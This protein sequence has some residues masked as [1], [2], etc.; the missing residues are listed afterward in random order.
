MAIPYNIPSLDIIKSFTKP[1]EFENWLPGLF[2]KNYYNGVFPINSKEDTITEETLFS[3]KTAPSNDDFNISLKRYFLFLYCLKAK[4]YL[5]D[6]ASKIINYNIDEY[7]FR[8]ELAEYLEQVQTNQIRNKI[9]SSLT[10]ELVKKYSLDKGLNLETKQLS[11]YFK[12]AESE[13]F[14]NSLSRKL[15]VVLYESVVKH[16]L[17][18]SLKESYSFPYKEDS[19]SGWINKAI[20]LELGELSYFIDMEG[21]PDNKSFPV[22]CVLTKKINIEEKENVL[23]Q[24]NKFLSNV[25]GRD[26]TDNCLANIIGEP[27]QFENNFKKVPILK[28]K[29][30]NSS[31]YNAICVVYDFT[32]ILLS[33]AKNREFKAQTVAEAGLGFLTKYTLELNSID[34]LIERKNVISDMFDKYFPSDSFSKTK[35]QIANRKRHATEIY[36]R[37][38]LLSQDEIKKSLEPEIKINTLQLKTAYSDYVDSIISTYKRKRSTNIQTSQYSKK[39]EKVTLHFDSSLNLLAITCVP[40]QI[41]DRATISYYSPFIINTGVSVIPSIT[42][43]LTVN[44]E[45]NLSDKFFGSYSQNPNGKFKEYSNNLKKFIGYRICFMTKTL[46][47]ML[48]DNFEGGK[49]HIAQYDNLSSGPNYHASFD[50]SS[51]LYESL[52]EI[53]YIEDYFNKDG[54]F[55]DKTIEI[56]SLSTNYTE[57]KYQSLS[58]QTLAFYL[59]NCYEGEKI[60]D[61]SPDVKVFGEQ[62]HYPVLACLPSKEE[63]DTSNILVSLNLSDNQIYQ[64]VLIIDNLAKKTLANLKDT[65]QFDTTKVVNTIM[66]SNAAC[67]ADVILVLEDLL[68]EILDF[69]PVTNSFAGFAEH[70]IGQEL[71]NKLLKITDRIPILDIIRSLVESLINQLLSLE[72]SNDPC[73]PLPKRIGFDVND[74]STPIEYL[75]DIYYDAYILGTDIRGFVKEIPKSPELDMWKFIYGFII[76]ALV[77]LIVRFVLA[78][79]VNLIR[80]SLEKIC[81]LDFDF[82]KLLNLEPSPKQ[83]EFFP[84]AVPDSFGN[85]ADAGGA[86]YDVQITID[87]NVLIDLSEIATRDFVYNKFAEE[88]IIPK[89]SDS[90]K[91][92]EGFLSQISP[93]MDLYELASLLRGFGTD[94]TIQTVADAISLLDI[95]FKD[96]FSNRDGV[97]KLFQFLSNYCDY[98]ILSP[99]SLEKCLT[100]I[101]F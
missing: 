59:I 92:I 64:E 88:F 54:K 84:S 10:I 15:N 13:D 20:N 58:L 90:I 71:G 25:F 82:I 47:R 8:P 34:N 91:E 6:A 41:N 12:V 9:N 55:I 95:S 49:N 98:N 42:F 81:N 39:D 56:A 45:V 85:I 27:D 72:V 62:F 2:G 7:L 44:Q 68:L 32:K 46:E 36:S 65:L 76:N 100:F 26:V 43:D 1:E 93:S 75:K 52:G 14:K 3:K 11:D 79:L 67:F 66:V 51:R 73:K 21:G 23:L 31:F 89:T 61:K 35:Y 22:V 83:L 87:I 69:D 17:Y 18:N 53:F 80:P 70:D 37:I 99:K 16:T 30:S 78:K 74:L 77:K 28:G 29:K 38:N 63:D 60:F 101:Y 57:T 4:P 48:Y 94:Y 86:L 96:T 19:A 40:Q 33:Q 50:I 97:I 5:F 24:T